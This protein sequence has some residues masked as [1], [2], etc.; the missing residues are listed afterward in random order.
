M[1]FSLSL[2]RPPHFFIIIKEL[3][4]PKE[5]CIEYGMSYIGSEIP[6]FEVL[7]VQVT[8]TLDPVGN[9]CS[10]GRVLIVRVGVKESV[11]G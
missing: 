9:T 5:I 8:V 2:L 4:W 11:R 10:S 6:S 7:L 1:L 3:S